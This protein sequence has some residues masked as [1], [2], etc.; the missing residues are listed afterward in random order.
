MNLIAN[1]R[2]L[3]ISAEA[4]RDEDNGGNVLSNLFAPLMNEFE[5]AQIYCSP[6]MPNN[7]V[8]KHYYHLSES[9]MLKSV[10][11]LR[12]FGTSLV[13]N[14]EN[15]SAVNSEYSET[16][17]S[18]KRYRSSL[19]YLIRDFLWGISQWKT[20]GLRKFILDFKPDLVF[21]PMY[22]SIYMHLIDR[23]VFS[24]A[25]VKVVSYVSDDHLTLRHHSYSPFFWLHRILLR[26]AVINTSK[27]YSLLY[28]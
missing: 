18:I 11:R 28:Q 4:W 19:L 2:I 24:I 9:D 26:R 12:K 15:E 23:F 8:C 13:I 20:S 21:A 14:Q 25:N 7:V 16:Y 10:V 5:F 6:A 27:S 3:I 17:N 1:K 22:G